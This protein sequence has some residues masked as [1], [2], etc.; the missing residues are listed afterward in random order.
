[1]AHAEDDRGDVDD[2]PA[3]SGEDDGAEERGGCGPRRP[4]IRSPAAGT[5][6][7]EAGSA[8]PPRHAPQCQVADGAGDTA[9]SAAENASAG[10]RARGCSA[11]QAAAAIVSGN[12]TS[13]KRGREISGSAPIG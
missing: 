11:S 13:K 4:G 1:D 3:D 9:I 7:G 2:H 8:A 10:I 6:G 12:S 5:P